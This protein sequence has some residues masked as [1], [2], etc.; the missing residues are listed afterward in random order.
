MKT[1]VTIIS[2]HLATLFWA[3]VATLLKLGFSANALNYRPI[4]LSSIPCKANRSLRGEKITKRETRIVAVR[5]TAGPE[6]GPKELGKWPANV[7]SNSQRSTQG[8]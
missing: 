6:W 1:L 8:S 2:H 4:S 5:R 7:P 3:V